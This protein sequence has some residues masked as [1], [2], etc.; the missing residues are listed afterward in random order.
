MTIGELSVVMADIVIDKSDPLNVHFNEVFKDVSDEK[1]FRREIMYLKAFLVSFRAFSVSNSSNRDEVN[2]A[3]K[4]MVEKL[5]E[6]FASNDY[7]CNPNI[8]DLMGAMMHYK[9]VFFNA[10]D[11][12]NNNY[13]KSKKYTS[14]DFEFDL[15][16]FIGTYPAGFFRFLN[17]K[18]YNKSPYVANSSLF[19]SCLLD[20]YQ[21]IKD[22]LEDKTRPNNG[23]CFVATATYQDAMHPDVV[24]LRDF[25]DRFLRKSFT[26]RMFIKVYYKVGPYLAYFP[27]QSL[28]I[29]KWSR[30]FIENLVIKIKEKYY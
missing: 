15:F 25:R 28:L 5:E 27:E 10:F 2:F 14:G 20:T 11:Y 4:M 18:P 24:L 1:Y 16:R 19:F 22:V 17:N 9:N 23:S 29:R 30:R 8:E 13:Y 3:T 21:Q 7:G 26:G 12:P 6:Y